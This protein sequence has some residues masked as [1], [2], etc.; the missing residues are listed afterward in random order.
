MVVFMELCGRLS[1]SEFS[2]ADSPTASKG[3]LTN[4]WGAD[5]RTALNWLPVS[6]S[7]SSLLKM[8]W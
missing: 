8:L 4:T 5:A 6:E 1:E 3:G 7:P 2:N